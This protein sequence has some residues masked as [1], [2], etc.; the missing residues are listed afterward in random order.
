MAV[1]N[2][3]TDQ[4]FLWA[5]LDD[6]STIPIYTLL[7]INNVELSITEE[8]YLQIHNPHT[9]QFETIGNTSL[10]GPAG[11]MPKIEIGDVTTVDSNAGASLSVSDNGETYRLNLVLPRG[12]Q[13]P[14]GDQGAEGDP[15]R[16]GSNGPQGPV[17]PVG[18]VGPQ[19]PQGDPGATGPAYYTWIKYASDSLGNG[20][21]N[22]PIN[23]DGTPLSYIGI[24]HNKTTQVASASASEYTWFCFKGQAY[25][26]WIKYADTNPID[27]GDIYDSPRD[28]TEY[29]GIAA[30]QTS[31]TASPDRTKY[32]WSKFKGK[33]GEQG[34]Q[35]EQGPQGPQGD[36]YYTQFPENPYDG[37]R[38]FWN[39]PTIES[40]SVPN[41]YAEIGEIY[42]YCTAETIPLGVQKSE[43][44]IQYTTNPE[45]AEWASVQ[46][47]S[48]MAYNF[49]QLVKRRPLNYWDVE[50]QCIRL[51]CSNGL[52][53]ET[54]PLKVIREI[55]TKADSYKED[56]NE[57]DWKTLSD[58]V[59]QLVDQTDPTLKTLYWKYNTKTADL[60]TNENYWVPVS[61][62]GRLE[63]SSPA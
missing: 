32:T 2:Y 29:I 43:I 63:D 23:G 34:E 9:N 17:G 19:G 36:P 26:T 33:K 50:H 62:L 20:M 39:G 37:Q 28:T 45:S 59:Q 53:T 22:D 6:G 56:E 41:G 16:P 44:C 5:Q 46:D 55:L 1:L 61:A 27:G 24:A 52:P 12:E 4:Q 57:G 8:G 58:T 13:G 35:G 3:D 31:K 21:S 11:K 47:S 40:A 30:N 42:E 38:V 51:D 7:N 15:G 14:Q 48:L 10:I 49:M 54:H 18:P 25:Y 60:T